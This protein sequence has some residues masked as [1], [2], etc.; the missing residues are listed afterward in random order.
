MNLQQQQNLIAIINAVHSAIVVTSNYAQTT[1]DPQQLAVCQRA[2]T[3]LNAIG[4]AALQALQASNS[5]LFQ[6]ETNALKVSTGQ[7]QA[8]EAQINAILQAGGIALQVVSAMVQIA[9]LVAV[10]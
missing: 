7:L 5:Q 1:S 6:Q 3:L 9:A 8:Q 10:L 4:T 2:I